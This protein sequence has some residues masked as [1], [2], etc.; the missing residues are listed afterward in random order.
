MLAATY[1]LHRFR[2]QP[3]C[4]SGAWGQ[5]HAQK[6]HSGAPSHLD[7]PS[8]PDALPSL[9]MDEPDDDV[10]SPAPSVCPPKAVALSEAERAEWAAFAQRLGLPP[11]P[12]AMMQ[13]SLPATLD[14]LGAEGRPSVLGAL[15][16]WG[17]EPI[18][19]RQRYA[20]ALGREWRALA[21]AGR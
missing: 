5:Y 21:D 2:S 17:V 16:G 6:F 10:A 3:V 9:D 20:N 15:K 7:A 12:A 4:M 11:E 19:L 8:Q 1:G 18:G 14:Q 13:A